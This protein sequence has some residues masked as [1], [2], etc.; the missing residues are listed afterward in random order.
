M[1]LLIS[2]SL[3]ALSYACSKRPFWPLGQG[4]SDMKE[5]QHV[6]QALACVFDLAGKFGAVQGNIRCE[7][8]ADW[9][10]AAMSCDNVRGEI[11]TDLLRFFVPTFLCWPQL[12]ENLS[13]G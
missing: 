12:L 9:L 8:Q 3:V 6:N 13:A 2:L 11:K 10:R 7:S 4:D 5:S 1:F